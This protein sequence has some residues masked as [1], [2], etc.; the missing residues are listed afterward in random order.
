MT[1]LM[2]IIGILMFMSLVV[3]HELGHF[4]AAKKT[5]VKVKEFW[6]G[7]PPK[8]CKL[9][10]DKSWTEYTLNR[11][12][13]GWFCALEGED[14][15]NPETFHAKDSFISAKLWKKLI[16]I[17]WWVTMNLITA[18]IIFTLLFWH[19]T[20]PLGISSE[21]SSESYLI[22]SMNFLQEQKL[23]S[24]TNGSGVIIQEITENS[25]ATQMGL[26][27]GDIILKVNQE[28]INQSTLVSTLTEYINTQNNTLTIQNSEGQIIE[29][30]FNCGDE[31][32]L[33][34]SITPN[35]TLE[36]LPVKFWLWWAM[37][38]SL[39]E[40]KA[41]RKLTFKALG[42]LGSS[43]FS[44]NG[45]RIK[46]AFNSL[47]G[48]VGAV[49]MGEMFYQSGG[50]TAYLAFAGLISLALAIFNLLPIPALDGGRGIGILLQAIFKIK[51]E[52]Y[53]QY[54]GYVNAIF[55]YLLLLLGVIIIVKDLIVFWWLS[56][57]FLS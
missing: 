3:L 22:P 32:K 18:W 51:P 5:W 50:R 23:L 4:W 19:G 45:G 1:I 33:G 9:G 11:I 44:F 36:L 10:T 41:E 35:S 26:V 13:L 39:H 12:P 34:I 57:P 28:E 25:L 27:T 21:Q 29:K 30:N 43:L 24:G 54:E 8:A 55:F 37:F 20:Q 52:K 53:F 49:K 14:P 15:S 2:I 42:K 48:P 17:I 47:A 6:I 40:I 38:A 16:I 31:C 7:L 56:I 46:D